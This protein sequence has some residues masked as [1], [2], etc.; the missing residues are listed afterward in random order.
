M[1]VQYLSDSNIWKSI[2]KI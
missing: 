2:K 1:K